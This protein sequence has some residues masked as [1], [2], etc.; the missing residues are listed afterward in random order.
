MLIQRFTTR[1]SEIEDRILL[2]VEFSD[3][4]T[5]TLCL[6]RRFLDRFIPVLIQQIDRSEQ[7]DAH[8]TM[9]QLFNQQAAISSLAPSAA[10][11]TNASSP[12]FLVINA[13]I[14]RNDENVRIIFRIKQNE[15]FLILTNT[16]LRQWLWIIYKAFQL[17][18]WKSDL[19]PIWFK[20]EMD[21]ANHVH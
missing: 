9:V 4:T 19:W 15:Y 17:A 2:H 7:R 5:A 8:Y 20:G 1:Y 14:Q 11:E 3:A 21:V 16:E 6:S 18:E 12:F 10:V 13:D